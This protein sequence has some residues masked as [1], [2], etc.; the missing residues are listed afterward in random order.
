MNLV[1]AS[2]FL[3]PQRILGVD[4]FSGLERHIRET[5][6]HTAI[7]PAVKPVAS[8]DLRA[9]D[10]AAQIRAHFP[11]GP[12]HI[13]AHSMGGL[14]SRVMIGNGFEGLDAPGRIASLTTLSTPH[15]GSPVA[16]LLVGDES[17]DLRRQWAEKI[18][19][20]ISLLGIDTGA[21]V[22]LT[23]DRASKFPNI[24]ASHPHIR[25]RSH[26]ASGRDQGP[27]TSVLLLLTHGYIKLVKQQE[28]DGLVT[29]DSARY[30]EFQ[31]PNWPCDHADMVGHNLDP[32]FPPVLPHLAKYD[33]IIAQL[34]S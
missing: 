22:D 19:V 20:A 17:A 5:S 2:G 16:D 23:R 18:N 13:I 27:P 32:L 7:F 9:R 24:V 6:T 25:V 3:I 28:S 12:V 8:S 14:D 29:L 10:L 4:Y 1:F 33:A 11:D 31:Q 34:G 21:L 15:N 26:W 30:G